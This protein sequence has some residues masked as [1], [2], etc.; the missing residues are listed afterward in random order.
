MKTCMKIV[1]N[2]MEED[3]AM[4]VDLER[5]ED[6]VVLEE[7]VVEVVAAEEVVLV[8]DLVMVVVLELEGELVVEREE[9][10]GEAVD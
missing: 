7:L 2:D 8:V 4:V 1:S 10:L 9:V 3:P 5:E 6:S